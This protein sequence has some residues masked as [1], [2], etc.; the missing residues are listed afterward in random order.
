M[1]IDVPTDWIAGLAGGGLIGLAAAAMLLG[2]GRIMGVSGILGGFADRRLPADWTERAMFLLGLLASPAVYFALGGEIEL[3]VTSSAPLIVLAGLLVGIG[4]RMGSGCTS[5]HGVC[6]VP[7][8][9]PRSIVSVA[10]FILAGIVTV[11]AMNA[12][13]V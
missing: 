13:G 4:T 1:P 10:I 11:T 9:S 7:R 2:N 8:L 3:Q 5:G 6:G 12:M